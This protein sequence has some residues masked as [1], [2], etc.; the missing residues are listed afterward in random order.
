MLLTTNTAKTIHFFECEA[1][2]LAKSAVP[3]YPS[4]LSAMSTGASY[5]QC[6]K[7]EHG[8]N[9]CM[10][11]PER[12]GPSLVSLSLLWA[13]LLRSKNL[14]SGPARGFILLIW[15]AKSCLAES[16]PE[17]PGIHGKFSHMSFME[18]PWDGASSSVRR[19]ALPNPPFPP[20][21]PPFPPVPP[22]I[23]AMRPSME[24]E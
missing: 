16:C 14:I 6:D 12:D 23:N 11:V 10:V 21:F 22:T 7:T 15:M 8:M 2:C 18:A 3:T 17:S 9:E 19:D 20:I 5:D 24:N 13:E 1:R 4:T